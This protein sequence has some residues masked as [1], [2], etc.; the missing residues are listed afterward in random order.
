M[1]HWKNDDDNLQIYFV[2]PN[3]VFFLT[4]NR[5]VNDHSN[6]YIMT[7]KIT[8]SITAVTTAIFELAMEEVV[9]DCDSTRVVDIFTETLVLAVKC[10]FPVV[11]SL[12]LNGTVVL[13]MVHYYTSQHN[14]IVLVFNAGCCCI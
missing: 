5:H 13:K 11:D 3:N 7:M 2:R 14:Y 8:M 10:I 12:M 1:K 6:N 4:T 9:G